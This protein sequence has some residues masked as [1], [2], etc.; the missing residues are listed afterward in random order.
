MPAVQEKLTKEDVNAIINVLVDLIDALHAEQHELKKGRTKNLGLFYTTAVT[1]TIPKHEKSVQHAY[2]LN[3]ID[4]ALG[5]NG[6]TDSF[7][8]QVDA[9]WQM[10]Q[11][12]RMLL[13]AYPF[14]AQ[15]AGWQS[16]PSAAGKNELITMGL[17]DV[18]MRCIIDASNK[19][20]DALQENNEA[21][22]QAIG[23]ILSDP[24]MTSVVDPLRSLQR[25]S[26]E[27]KITRFEQVVNDMHALTTPMG[28]PSRELLQEW[29]RF[30]A[31][32][33][34][35]LPQIVPRTKEAATPEVEDILE[36][37]EAFN[38]QFFILQQATEKDYT[39]SLHS[40]ISHAER[41]KKDLES[42]TQ[43]LDPEAEAF[44]INQINR[45]IADVS[46]AQSKD[47]LQV[48]FQRF[49]QGICQKL[50][51]SAPQSS[52]RINQVSSQISVSEQSQTET[53]EL[54]RPA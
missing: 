40:C 30:R 13:R 6:I 44:I 45:F 20:L 47:E 42:Q 3:I 16:T 39:K 12:V 49:I 4:R 21:A 15:Q 23:K 11:D 54:R 37:L 10:L 53:V 34:R 48:A 52:S 5:K 46:N 17:V 7:R 28:N 41:W 25:T 8:V 26:L 38:V 27:E 19:L 24:S 29:A 2:L 18:H 31:E 36:R 51:K 50:L 43:V 32:M 14:E 22:E 9:F 33:G 35:R 1:R